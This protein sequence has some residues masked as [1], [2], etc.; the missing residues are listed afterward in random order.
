MNKLLD[1]CSS[2]C[3]IF[4][5]KINVTTL[6]YLFYFHIFNSFLLHSHNIIFPLPFDSQTWL[7][8]PIWR[9]LCYHWKMAN[10]H[11]LNFLQNFESSCKIVLTPL[12]YILFYSNPNNNHIMLFSAQNKHFKTFTWKPVVFDI[13]IC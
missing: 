11:I 12:L 1:S 7:K 4:T 3:S 2:D 8:G 6:L 13:E 5:L 10:F 9:S